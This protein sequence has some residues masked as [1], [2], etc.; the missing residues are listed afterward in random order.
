MDYIIWKSF[1]D[2]EL[3]N[4]LLHNLEITIKSRLLDYII[5]NIILD[6]L[7]RNMEV[8]QAG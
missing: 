3:C 1:L 2:S 4:S 5:R 8:A 7:I 6:Y